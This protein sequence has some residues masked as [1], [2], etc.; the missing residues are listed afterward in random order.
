MVNKT[1]LNNAHDDDDKG[2]LEG[3]RIHS[4]I[5]VAYL[6][7]LAAARF[8][9]M[10]VCARLSNFILYLRNHR[11]EPKDTVSL[12]VIFLRLAMHSHTQPHPVRR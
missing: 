11:I 8:Y 9:E 5:R 6:P 3:S 10:A 4:G 1:D 12:G 7:W 2:D